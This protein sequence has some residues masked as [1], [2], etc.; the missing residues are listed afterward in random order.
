MEY[1]IFEK[2]QAEPE[3]KQ[4]I[5]DGKKKAL[6][7][8]KER[9]ES[10]YTDDHI[11]KAR[12]GIDKQTAI[13]INMQ[14]KKTINKI[15][16]AKIDYFSMFARCWVYKNGL[17]PFRALAEDI[18]NQIYIDIRY[19]DFSNYETFKKCLNIT[20]KTAM[21]G[22]I[23]YYQV[24]LRERKAKYYLYHTLSA[25]SA[26]Q[27]KGFD[28]FALLE[29]INAL[30]PEEEIIKNEEEQ[31]EE[32]KQKTAYRLQMLQEIGKILPPRAKE[33]FAKEFLIN[34]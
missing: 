10:Y 7:R 2:I 5:I 30:K 21:T 13:K 3:F 14:N 31:S 4:G 26:K 11:L 28:F 12:F 18:I 19:Y 25:Q 17:L 34:G 6:E 27:S 8:V 24:W 29:D 23:V 16:F 32:F 1:S 15:Y 22:G 33:Y 20:A 9:L